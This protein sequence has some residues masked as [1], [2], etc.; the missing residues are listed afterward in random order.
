MSVRQDSTDTSFAVPPESFFRPTSQH[1]TSTA[2]IESIAH[3]ATKMHATANQPN[4]EIRITNRVGEL[5]AKLQMA[6]NTV[7]SKSRSRI[8]N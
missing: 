8:P 5:A 3:T 1:S 4:V 6:E 2:Q 7:K